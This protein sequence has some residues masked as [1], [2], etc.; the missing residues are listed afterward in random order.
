MLSDEILNFLSKEEVELKDILFSLDDQ[1]HKYRERHSR[2]NLRS[3]E[4]TAQLVAARRDVDRQMIASEEAVS[5]KLRDSWRGELENI[6]ALKESP[7]FAKVIVEES[8]THGTNPVAHRLIEYKL[9]K[10]SNTDCR[11]VDWKASP[12]SKLFYEYRE[13]EEYCEIIQGRE[14][15]GRVVARVKYRIAEGRLEAISCHYGDF[16]NQEGNWRPEVFI[17]SKRKSRSALPDVMSLITPDQFRAITQEAD[18]AVFIKGIA[19]SGKTT[20]SL[21]RLTWQI[22]SSSKPASAQSTTSVPLMSA[23]SDV[24]TAAVIVKTPTL[25]SYAGNTLKLL[26]H[27]NIKAFT[28]DEW[29]YEEFRRECSPDVILQL[30]PRVNE[31]IGSRL[32]ALHRLKHSVAMLKHID[33]YVRDQKARLVSYLSQF[34]AGI[35]SEFANILVKA[36][37]ADLAI[38]EIIDMIDVFIETK[39]SSVVEALRLKAEL[40]TLKRKLTI[41][42]DELSLLYSRADSLMRLDLT[43]LIDRDTIL[44]AKKSYEDARSQGIVDMSD[45]LLLLLLKQLKTGRASSKMSQYNF[46]MVD[47]VQD[48]S[49]LE[50]AILSNKVS[51]KSGLTLVGD[52]AQATGDDYSFPAWAALN[53]HWFDSQ[54]VASTVTLTVSQRCSGAIMKFANFLRGDRGFEHPANSADLKPGKPPLHLICTNESYGVRSVVGWLNKLLDHYPGTLVAVLCASPV[55]SRYV[56]SLLKPTFA[57][58][59]RLAEEETSFEEGIIVADVRSVKGLEFPFALIWNPTKRS[60]PASDLG[61]NMLYVAATRAEELLCVVSWGE[62][63][64]LFPPSTSRLWR[65][66]DR[67]E[68]EEE[69]A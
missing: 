31:S 49:P 50:L 38:L 13:G 28:F 10:H 7:Y 33:Q 65:V 63:S 42:I 37:S 30:P 61:Q 39:T 12:I 35:G 55:E 21:H 53:K 52:V 44:N 32:S 68:E 34:I 27:E 41:Y 48:F 15:A 51:E 26:N 40:P 25:K 17:A 59:L 22:E 57:N 8:N 54:E 3:R 1:I 60:Y 66:R 58:L 62:I 24:Q 64:T 36:Q 16:I 2:E 14:R 19:G 11:I 69:D 9:G 29:L 45:A 4:L 67:R 23:H 18:G 6:V 5:Y 20:V 47:E 56:Y 46:L 43:R